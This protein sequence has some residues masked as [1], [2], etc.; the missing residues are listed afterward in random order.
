F[1]LEE[2]NGHTRV[3]WQIDIAT[4]RPRNILNLFSNMDKKMAND[5]ALG[6][7]H[8]KNA[9]E[10]NT[11]ASITAKTYNVQPFNFPSTSFGAYREKI[12]WESIPVFYS[13]WL[14][15]IASV[16][17]KANTS[18][19]IPTGLY[20]VWDEVNKETDMAAAFEIPADTR[21]NNDS[22]QV[23]TIAGSKAVY[24]DY[25]GAYDKSMD[26]YASIDKYLAENNLKQKAPVIEQ[27]MNDPMQVKDTSKWHTKIIFL[28]E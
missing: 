2:I 22:F 16:I 4:P 9:I 21:L 5:F 27:Y 15:R 26:A 12:T 7:Q 28:V 13:T 18:P 10:G 3:R 6:L 20:Y 19:G 8:L 14:P 24:T 23:I 25:Y 11:T 17:V 1:D